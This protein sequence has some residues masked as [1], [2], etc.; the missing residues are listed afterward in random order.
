MTAK[1][2]HFIGIGGIGMSGLAEILLQKG[3]KV[4]GSDLSSNSRILELQKKGALI[5][6]QH[7]CQNIASDSVVIYSTGISQ[8]NPEI[9]FAKEQHCL[10]LHRSDLLHTLMQNY[11]P[12]LVTG[13]HGKTTTTSLL[14]TVLLQAELFP[15]YAIGGILDSGLNASY[16]TGKFF[17]AEA[18]ESDGSFLKYDPFAAIITN[19]DNDHMNYYQKESYLLDAFKNF[20]KKVKSTN[21]LFYCQDDLKL[22]SLQLKGLSYG[23]CS[24]SCVQGI[25]FK[26][27]AWEIRFDALFDQKKYS[28]IRVRL[29]GMHNALNAL[30]VFGLAL[31]LGISEG[32]I[33]QAFLNFRGVKRRAE[34]IGEYKD[35]L[36]LD[37]YGH[38]PTEIATTLKG[39][40]QAAPKRNLIVLF[41]PHRFTRT[42]DCLK[43]FGTCFNS[44]DDVIITDI[45]SAN[46]PQIEGINSE[47]VVKEINQHSNVSVKYVAKDHLTSLLIDILKP[48]DIVVTM[49][50]GDIYKEGFRL[51]E[52]LKSSN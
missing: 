41:Q 19:I 30:A 25:N 18:D 28:D 51:L 32:H 6:L 39:I 38:H 33:R 4:T 17:V 1:R 20:A 23:F 8:D 34:K 15:S 27:T 14:T 47:R 46:E 52:R 49:G 45:Y 2:Y 36:I 43:Q 11:Q 24:Q 13:T 5:R 42:R 7:D 44:A 48:Q 50:A 21:H 9:L 31:Q 29:L 40:K 22:Q 37:D 16:G 12:L 10:L 26:Q 35:I 3:A